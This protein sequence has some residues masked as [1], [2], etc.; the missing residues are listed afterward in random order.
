LLI[1]VLG[2]LQCRE[3][4]ILWTWFDKKIVVSINFIC[5]LWSYLR[6][7]SFSIFNRQLRLCTLKLYYFNFIYYYWNDYE[8]KVGLS[9]GLFCISS[10]GIWK[11]QILVYGSGKEFWVIHLFHCPVDENYYWVICG[12]KGAK[13]RNFWRK[14]HFFCAHNRSI[15]MQYSSIFFFTLM[16]PGACVTIQGNNC[17]VWKPRR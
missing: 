8:I 9:K 11:R 13:Q 12:E 5:P 1:A 10:R 16:Y 3:S 7:A 2:T 15:H 4:L 14:K 6:A 17:T